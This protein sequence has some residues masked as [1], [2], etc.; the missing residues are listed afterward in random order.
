MHLSNC[1]SICTLCNFEARG[2]LCVAP[3]NHYFCTCFVHLIIK[4]D[5][6]CFASVV[7]SA[8]FSLPEAVLFGFLIVHS[9]LPGTFLKHM[10]LLSRRTL[11]VHDENQQVAIISRYIQFVNKTAAEIWPDFTLTWKWNPRLWKPKRT[12]LFAFLCDAYMQNK[13]WEVISQCS[14]IINRAFGCISCILFLI[15]ARSLKEAPRFLNLASCITSSFGCFF[16]FLTVWK[17]E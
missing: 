12:D 1:I 16:F 7:L 10:V 4:K 17:H 13:L 2:L 8:L 5:G 15:S 14:L 3:T 11:A 6:T 9:W